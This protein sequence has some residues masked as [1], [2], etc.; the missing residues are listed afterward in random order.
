MCDMEVEDEAGFPL[1]DF[2]RNLNRY[3]RYVPYEIVQNLHP[4][5]SGINRNE[6]ISMALL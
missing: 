6:Y 4:D 2:V 5:L 3:V 1:Y